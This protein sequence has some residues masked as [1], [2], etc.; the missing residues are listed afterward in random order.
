MREDTLKKR[1][2]I[3]ISVA[4]FA[5]IGLAVF[6]ALRYALPFLMPFIIGFAIAF[7]LKPVSRFFCRRLHL[8]GNVCGAAVVIL[9]YLLLIGVLWFIGLHVV[10][11]VASFASSAQQLYDT[12]I[13]PL[14]AEL[15]ELC[16]RLTESIAPSAAGQTNQILAG[17]SQGVSQ[18]VAAVS[19]SL[20]L[21]LADIG[22][23]IP[24][25]IIGLIF[26]VMSSIFISSDYSNVASFLAKLFPKKT[27]K[28]L[29]QTKGYAVA[30]VIQYLRAYLILMLITFAELTIGLFLIRAE[31]AIGAAAVIAICDALPLLGTG[32]ILLP[33]C[34]LSFSMGHISF[35]VGLLMIYLVIG[36]LRNFLEPKILGKQLGLHPLA[37][38]FSVY[39][40]MK[41]LGVLGMILLPIL[42]QISVCVYRELHPKEKAPSS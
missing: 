38:L 12:Y 14:F 30:T 34:L 10:D 26:A 39:V 20:L 36:L 27:R 23:N 17:L 28:L 1:Q 41:L 19:Q 25:F 22:M 42:L 13:A 3:L 35:A 33:W 15:N 32:F 37:T 7:A 18:A 16:N 8:G 6:F 2:E 9:A 5:L 4:Y 29:F 31:N 40:G 11:V 21:L 24:G